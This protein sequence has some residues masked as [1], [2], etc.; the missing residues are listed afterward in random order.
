MNRNRCCKDFFFLEP[1]YFEGITLKKKKKKLNYVDAISKLEE[2]LLVDPVKH[3]AL[4]CLGNAQTSQ[5]FLTPDIDE[6]KVFF[7][8]ARDYFQKAAD[9]VKF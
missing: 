6:A 1:N 3:E 2:A 5:A 4:W 9:E 8:K 7:D